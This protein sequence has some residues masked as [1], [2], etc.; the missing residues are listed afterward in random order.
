M[1]GLQ[2]SPQCL[3]ISPTR[4][5]LLGVMAGMELGVGSVVVAI[6]AR[7]DGATYLVVLLGTGELALPEDERISARGAM[8]R[9]RA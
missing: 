8:G 4:G 2:I 1:H 5:D 3:G 6:G 9:S 7:Q